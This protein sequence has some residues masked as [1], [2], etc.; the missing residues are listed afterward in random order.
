MKFYARAKWGIMNRVHGAFMMASFGKPAIVI[1]NDSRAKMIENL[2]LPS[3]YVNDVSRVG[4]ESLIDQVRSRCDSY[5]E[6]MEEIRRSSRRDYEDELQS[7]LD[8]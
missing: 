4:A 5:P 6:Q 1:G 8:K 2:S 7:V 3:Y